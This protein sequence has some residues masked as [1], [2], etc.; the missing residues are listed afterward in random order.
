MVA[1]VSVASTHTTR[2]T[3]PALLILLPIFSYAFSISLT[4]A[5][6]LSTSSP[7]SLLSFSFPPLLLQVYASCF[8][9]QPPCSFCS[10]IADY[11]EM[12]RCNCHKSA[13]EDGRS[14]LWEQRSY[15]RCSVFSKILNNE[16]TDGR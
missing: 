6:T 5:S 15:L 16:Y 7:W 12:P 14:E 9:S 2:T 1:S 11:L 3:I 13:R 8:P 10:L 4:S